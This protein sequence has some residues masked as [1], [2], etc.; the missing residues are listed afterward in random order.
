[1]ISY[2]FL[3][4]ALDKQIQDDEAAKAYVEATRIN[5]DDTLAWQGLVSLYERQSGNRIDDYHNAVVRLAEL[6]MKVYV[7]RAALVYYVHQKLIIERVQR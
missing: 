7:I 3:G 4:L 1:M 5:R 2:V 6:F